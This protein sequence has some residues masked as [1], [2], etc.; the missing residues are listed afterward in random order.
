MNL[1]I[2]LQFMN[3]STNESFNLAINLA[4]NP[5]INLSSSQSF[6]HLKYQSIN[7]QSIYQ[8]INQSTP[9]SVPEMF[10]PARR[11]LP[12][13]PSRRSTINRWSGPWRLVL[14]PFQG[15]VS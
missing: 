9:P 3:T 15:P 4:I 6:N 1:H 2:D 10:V 12:Q 7:P 14:E 11:T 8:S 5:S 13:V